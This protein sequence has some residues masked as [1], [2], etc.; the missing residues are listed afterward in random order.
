MSDNNVASQLHNITTASGANLQ[1]IIAS[2]VQ[3]PDSKIGCYAA[4]SESYTAFAPLFDYVF[5]N[6]HT[7]SSDLVDILKSPKVIN[8]I[9]TTIN[10]SANSAISST[11]IRVARNVSDLPFP[12]AM[13]K[14]Q[15]LLLEA[16]TIKAIQNIPLLNGGTYHSLVK[17]SSE[18]YQYFIDKHL[19]FADIR[20]DRFLVA[21]GIA[22]DWAAGRGFYI[23]KDENIII[24]INEE[25]HLR[26]ISLQNNADINAVFA[27]LLQIHNELAKQ[28]TFAKHEKYGYLASCPTNIGTGMRASVHLML[29]Y[30]SKDLVK[31]KLLAKQIGIDIRNADG[32]HGAN[33]LPIFDIS[34]SRRVAPSMEYLLNNLIIGVNTLYS[35]EEQLSAVQ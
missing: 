27:N 9:T 25:D 28:L 29:P 15:R 1:K 2:G 14:K 17:I 33:N 13:T 3:N 21:A 23:S 6:Y 5:D 18:K 16:K 22:D 32:E 19:A 30:L 4:D 31:L 26:I 24:W 11:R 34:N 7:K 35:I 20:G 10:E 12:S 8:S